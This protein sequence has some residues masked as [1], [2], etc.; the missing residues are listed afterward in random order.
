VTK[1][2]SPWDG[3]EDGKIDTRRVDASARWNW[4][5]AVMPGADAALVLQLRNCPNPVPELPKL[6]TV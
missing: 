2:D 5:W 4:F 3:L 1:N 6:L